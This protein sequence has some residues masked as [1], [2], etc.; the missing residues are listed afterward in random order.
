MSSILSPV[1]NGKYEFFLFHEGITYNTILLITII[2]KGES[3]KSSMKW[4]KKLESNSS[5]I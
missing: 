4:A 3:K 1:K 5:L 2:K